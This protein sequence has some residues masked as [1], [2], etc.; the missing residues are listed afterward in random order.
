[1][2]ASKALR[3]GLDAFCFKQ[4]EATHIGP[5]IPLS[6]SE[7][8][9]H[10]NEK[11]LVGAQMVDGYVRRLPLCVFVTLWS[12]TPHFASTFLYL[13]FSSALCLQCPFPTPYC[14]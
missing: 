12:G 6:T 9:S 11:L 1:M 13:L 4:F 2:N 14:P 7:F 3:V 8:L 5:R 10:I